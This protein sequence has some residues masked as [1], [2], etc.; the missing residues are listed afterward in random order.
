MRGAETGD[1]TGMLVG[2]GAP[3]VSSAEHASGGWA[4]SLPAVTDLLV[5]SIGTARTDMRI[6]F[7]YK[8]PIAPPNTINFFC[9]YAPSSTYFRLDGVSGGA[10]RLTYVAADAQLYIIPQTS[11]NRFINNAWNEFVI[12]IQAGVEINV[13]FNGVLA[14]T[15]PLNVNVIQAFSSVLWRGTNAF[16]DDL[17]ITD[18]PS[19][20]AIDGYRIE[21]VVPANTLAPVTSPT[22]ALYPGAVVSTT[23]GTW[24]SVPMSYSYQWQ[25]D[26]VNI[27]GATSST[28][29]LTAAD[30]G[31]AIRCVVTATN[32]AGSA[33]ANSNATNAVRWS[34]AELIGAGLAMWFDADDAASITQAAGLVSQI[35]DKSGGGWHLTQ[36]TGGLQPSIAPNAAFN[37]R[38]VLSAT[39]A[40]GMFGTYTNADLNEYV[41]AAACTLNAGAQSTARLFGLAPTGAGDISAPNGRAPMARATT[42][43]Q[44]ATRSGSSVYGARTVS[45]DAPLAYIAVKN[46]TDILSA[47]N[48]GTP[49]GSVLATASAP[50]TRHSL[51]AGLNPSAP[52]TSTYWYGFM[53]EEIF[54]TGIPSQTILDKLV[55]YLAWKWSQTIIDALPAGHPYKSVA[56]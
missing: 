20:S 35:N 2:G 25:G 46:P 5:G 7:R 31:K 52:S 38:S 12:S 51:F 54:V 17:V 37:N 26:G 28:Y 45:Y 43:A 49:V 10:I 33:S 22:T 50:I 30:I 6:S 19:N 47:V 8:S 55:G 14:L 18:T 32:V 29:T 34:P 39:A 40:Q 3:T 4:Y 9:A 44:I 41:S 53:A 56:P 21:A 42:N 36:A 23:N 27:S 16:V 11:A 13:W 15:A 48:G 1:L 24:A